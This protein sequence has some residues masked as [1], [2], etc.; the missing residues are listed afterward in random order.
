MRYVMS[1]SRSPR[2][3]RAA[4]RV[5][6]RVSAVETAE[7]WSRTTPLFSCFAVRRDNGVRAV[8]LDLGQSPFLRARQSTRKDNRSFHSK[9]H[10]VALYGNRKT[11]PDKYHALELIA[12]VH[13][14][15]PC[16]WKRV[17]ALNT[18]HR[19][20]FSLE[21]SDRLSSP[22]LLFYFEFEPGKDDSNTRTQPSF[23]LRGLGDTAEVI[24]PRSPRRQL[25]HI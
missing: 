16:P 19:V 6:R 4:V 10:M 18:A 22:Q 8:W 13:R 5:F 11:K 7:D 1:G 23:A 14:S 2:A 20:F 25:S 15:F 21:A 9:I 12:I 3:V 24:F 17:E